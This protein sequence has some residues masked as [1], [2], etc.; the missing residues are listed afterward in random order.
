M[1]L[2][3]IALVGFH[4]DSPIDRHVAQLQAASSLSVKFKVN[5]IGAGV[6]DQELVLA[7][8]NLLRWSTPTKLIVSDGKTVTTLD[9][10]K[11]TYS[12][13]PYTETWAKKLLTDD[14][15]WAWGAFFN[16]DFSKTLKSATRGSQSVVKGATLVRY[17]CERENLKPY[18]VLL[19]NGVGLVKG[20]LYENKAGENVLVQS[21]SFTL[22]NKPLD[23]SGFVFA[24]PANAVE[25][26]P[27]D[28]NKM[29]K[30]ADISDL[31]QKNCAGCHGASS[32]KAGISLNTYQS[33]IDSNTI[34]AG[35]PDNSK[36]IKV[37]RSGQM[38]P[39][40]KLASETIDK[41]AK[42]VKDGA[43]E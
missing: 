42:W 12:Q 22:S 21:E 19:D 2:P 25:V 40:R 33:M 32:P 13:I 43:Q 20:G 37:M 30:Y 15:V 4:H 39:R 18:T 24:A 38:P 9:K 5:T 36:F 1:A 34:V 14:A 27:D 10:Q 26:K 11:N 6:E 31:V 8:P 41:L 35:D 28:P 23:P 17:T 3:F 29:L 16:K 7:R